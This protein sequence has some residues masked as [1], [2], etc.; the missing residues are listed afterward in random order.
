MISLG[1]VGHSNLYEFFSTKSSDIYLIAVN[2]FLVRKDDLSLFED[3]YQNYMIDLEDATDKHVNQ[4]YKTLGTFRSLAGQMIEEYVSLVESSL[5]KIVSVSLSNIVLNLG[6]PANLQLGE[7]V[8]KFEV[9]KLVI[10]GNDD[11]SRL[12]FA[13]SSLT[14]LSILAHVTPIRSDLM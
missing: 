8:E 12:S 11:S 13:C 3:S 5:T 2:A 6:L 9:S 14:L 1:K 4:S 10:V 7:K